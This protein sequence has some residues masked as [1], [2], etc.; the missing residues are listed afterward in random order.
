MKPG[1]R[2]SGSR[3]FAEITLRRTAVAKSYQ[4]DPLYFFQSETEGG[5]EKERE[6][7]KGRGFMNENGGG[8]NGH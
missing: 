5:R 4:S 7:E 1:P 3:G 2:Y 8:R 6:K